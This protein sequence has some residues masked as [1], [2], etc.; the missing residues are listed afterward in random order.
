MA[1][2]GIRSI[3][4]NPGPV[5]SDRIYKTVYPKAAAEFLRIGGF[6]GLTNKQIE[7]ATFILLQFL[8]EKQD[9]IEK[10]AMKIAEKIVEENNESNSEIEKYKE[11]LLKLIEKVQEIAEEGTI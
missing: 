5:H 10:E 8:G 4:T 9:I 3:G 11:I 7:N 6:K 2:K 1:E